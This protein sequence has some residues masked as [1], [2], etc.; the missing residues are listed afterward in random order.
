MPW[1]ER[2]PHHPDNDEIMLALDE[3]LA[4]LL[5]IANALGVGKPTQVL[6]TP[7]TPQDNQE[8]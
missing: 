4:V 3:I 8:S 6:G 7:G 5:L 2:R 1:L